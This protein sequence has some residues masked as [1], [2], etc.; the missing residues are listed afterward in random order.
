M[1]FALF[2]FKWT[3]GQRKLDQLQ[4]FAMIYENAK[5]NRNVPDK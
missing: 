1:S 3:C 4:N 5:E 2:I